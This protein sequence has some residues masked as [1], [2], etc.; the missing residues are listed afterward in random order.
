MNSISL[1]P[2]LVN[3]IEGDYTHSR[4]WAYSLMENKSICEDDNWIFFT[5]NGFEVLVDFQLEV[6]GDV[7]FIREDDMTPD[8]IE[9]NVDS[10]D[11]KVK[12][13]EIDGYSVSLN[14][15]I[16]AEVSKLISKLI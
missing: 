7:E 6:V 14:D 12:S 8:Y 9:E 3:V 10:I 1:D 13:I 16:S 15:V 2:I 4:N 5:S 11:I